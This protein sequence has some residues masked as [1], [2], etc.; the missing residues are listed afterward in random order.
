M[1]RIVLTCLLPAGLTRNSGALKMFEHPDQDSHLEG[2][3]PEAEPEPGPETSG[4][5]IVDAS[6]IFL[7]RIDAVVLGPWT[8]PPEGGQV[9]TANLRLVLLEILKGK[10]AQT[11]R[12]A[13]DLAVLQRGG[14]ILE[15]PGV[16]SSVGLQP[17][18]QLV[19]FSNGPSTDAR[20]LLTGAHIVRFVEAHKVMDDTRAAMHLESEHAPPDNVLS[21]AATSPER[22]GDTF[23]R[24]AWVRDRKRTRLNS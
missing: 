21:V 24:Y 7:F 12:E 16:W 18:I 1:S 22:W 11:P 17:G 2:T 23:A 10:L 20:V 8:H 15:D 4:S 9:R 6:A 5:E 14:P 3:A 13:F 19:A